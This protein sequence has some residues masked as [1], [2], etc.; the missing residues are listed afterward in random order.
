MAMR[1]ALVLRS[2]S[3]HVAAAARVAAGQRR[4]ARGRRGAEE[5]EH[6]H[7]DE[8]ASQRVSDALAL[9]EELKDHLAAH[10]ASEA[11]SDEDLLLYEPKP[12]YLVQEE[13]Q[14][15]NGFLKLRDYLHA[16]MWGLPNVYR[17]VKGYCHRG[18]LQ[19]LRQMQDYMD[20]LD[21][22]EMGADEYDARMLKLKSQPMLRPLVPSF[23]N[24]QLAHALIA[25]FIKQMKRLGSKRLIIYEFWG[26]NGQ[27]AASVLDVLQEEHPELYAGCEYHMVDVAGLW[28]T[29]RDVTIK[30]HHPAHYFEHHI[31]LFDWEVLVEDRVFV[32]ALEALSYLPF[33]RVDVIAGNGLQRPDDGHMEGNLYFYETHMKEDDHWDDRGEYLASKFRYSRYGVHEGYRPLQDELILQYLRHVDF[34]VFTPERLNQHYRDTIQTAARTSDSAEVRYRENVRKTRNYNRIGDFGGNP[35]KLLREAMNWDNNK[36]WIPSL[37]VS[38]LDKL[39]RYFPRHTLVVLEHCSQHTYMEGVNPPIGRGHAWGSHWD[40]ATTHLNE[41]AFGATEMRFQMNLQQFRQ[42][43]YG[44]MEL[45][46][47]HPLHL[48]CMDMPAFFEEYGTEELRDALTI[49]NKVIA[50]PSHFFLGAR[51]MFAEYGSDVDS[52]QDTPRNA[53]HDYGHQRQRFLNFISHY[54]I[55][56]GLIGEGTMADAR[57]HDTFA[58]MRQTVDNTAVLAAIGPNPTPEQLDVPVGFHTRLVKEKERV[59][60]LESQKQTQRVTPS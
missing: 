58:D 56:F 40:I 47:E 30:A 57:N 17:N 9:R 51:L 55:K 16:A 54:G 33:D 32:L 44:M 53:A 38:F 14:H 41:T 45:P 42:L 24:P 29:H 49:N 3:S 48:R 19:E 43:Y 50:Q 20:E 46:P 60:A 52:L 6:E 26:F 22:G 35:F 2:G 7:E 37:H 1:S 39:R 10:E 23:L 59:A 15:F 5:D 21:F 28:M 13:K 12:L 36:F 25:Y 18:R 27:T 8:E 11:E 4:Y 34:G 31:S